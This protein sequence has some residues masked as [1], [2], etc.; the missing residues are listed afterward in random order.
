MKKLWPFFFLFI[1]GLE[2]QAAEKLK[3]NWQ[4]GDVKSA[5]ALALKEQKPLF[6]YWGAVWCPPCNQIK[7]TIFMT[8]VF[9]SELANYIAVYLDSILARLLVEIKLPP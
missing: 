7:K 8:N 9:Q 2:I 1:I 6:I 4:K 3:G 5:L